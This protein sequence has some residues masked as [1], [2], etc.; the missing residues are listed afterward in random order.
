M[1]LSSMLNVTKWSFFY[2]LKPGLHKHKEDVVSSSQKIGV[3]PEEPRPVVAGF[4]VLY[5]K[6]QVDRFSQT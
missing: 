3:R 2:R 6:L 1:K 4:G 5:Y